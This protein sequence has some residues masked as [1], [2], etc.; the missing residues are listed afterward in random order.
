MQLKE[1]KGNAVHLELN[2]LLCPQKRAQW[3]A[4]MFLTSSLDNVFDYEFNRNQQLWDSLGMCYSTYKTKF[5]IDHSHDHQ[6]I[7]LWKDE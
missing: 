7:K 1:K 5:S 4:K 2:A 6:F 3:S